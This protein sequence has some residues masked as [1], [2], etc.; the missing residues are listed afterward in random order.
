[1]RGK[2]IVPALAAAIT[3]LGASAAE[4]DPAVEAR[5][6]RLAAYVETGHACLADLPDGYRFDAALE[7]DFARRINEE[8]RARGLPAL[9]VRT[10]LRPAARWH[11]LDMGLNDFFAHLGPD[12][13]TPKARIT[14]FDRTLLSSVQRENIAA[15]LGPVNWE[16]V[17][18]RLHAGLMDSPSHREAILADDVTHLAIGVAR[19]ETGIWVTQ[20]FVRQ[21]G[22]FETPVPLHLEAG[23]T[24]TRRAALDGW[25]ASGLALIK[26]GDV[27][28][29]NGR[30]KASARIPQNARGRQMLSVRGEKP[31]SKPGSRLFMHFTGPGVEVVSRS[32][33]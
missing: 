15:L 32:S 2:W 23:A 3:A 4:C 25:T 1:M 27:R 16:T 10:E 12:E 9:A 11:S 21:E 24:V 28:D 30:G 17:V 20:L 7:A 29:L 5:A 19:G 13:R 8:R 26:D 31:G 22:T 33:S 14:A 18:E 6:E